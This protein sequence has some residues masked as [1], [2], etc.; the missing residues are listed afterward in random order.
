MKKK[1]KHEGVSK[2]G[3]GPGA[4]KPAHRQVK[5]KKEDSCDCC[6][7]NAAGQRT[8]QEDEASYARH[9]GT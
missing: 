2:L 9:G 3:T 7:I 8:Q 1:S 4:V 6:I 5:P